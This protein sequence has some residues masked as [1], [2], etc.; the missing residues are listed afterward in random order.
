MT[1]IPPESFHSASDLDVEL[2]F[3]GLWRQTQ[4][5]AADLKLD[6]DGQRVRTRRRARREPHRQGEC[7][8]AIEGECVKP[9]VRIAA[10][11]RRRFHDLAASENGWPFGTVMDMAMGPPAGCDSAYKCQPGSIFAETTA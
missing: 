3:H 6:L 8:G 1:G 2:Q 4:A 9:E 11:C 10:S 5:V 7:R